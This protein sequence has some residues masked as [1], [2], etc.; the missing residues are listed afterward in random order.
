MYCL[1]WGG[2]WLTGVVKFQG[3]RQVPLWYAIWI[4]S[5]DSRQW[6]FMVPC[7]F[8]MFCEIKSAICLSFMVSLHGTE[9]DVL[10]N[11]PINVKVLSSQFDTGRCAIESWMMSVHCPHDICSGSS[12][13]NSLWVTDSKCL[14]VFHPSTYLF[15]YSVIDGQAKLQNTSDIVFAMLRQPA[16]LLVCW[17]F[18]IRSFIR[19][20][21]PMILEKSQIF[22]FFFLEKSDHVGKQR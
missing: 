5:H 6:F 21:K 18:R 14:H 17:M 7:N 3:D 4:F 19:S 2:T 22:F 16:T 9:W 13:L 10:V 1:S 20:H 11:L 12:G 15:T 8:H